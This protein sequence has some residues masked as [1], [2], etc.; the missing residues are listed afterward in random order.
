M[1]TL[2]EIA[3]LVGVSSTTVSRV[4][5]Y[6]P[7]LTMPSTK[8]QAI[9]EAAEAMNYATPRNRGKTME[10]SEATPS[11]RF[12]IVHFLDPSEEIADPFYVGVRLGIENKCRELNIDVTKIFS[13][14]GPPSE[15]LL[16]AASG[17]IVIGKHSSGQIEHLKKEARH[18]VFADFDPGSDEL[19]SVFSDLDVA[20][21]KILKFLKESGYQRI[22]FI[23]TNDI[24]D[25]KAVRYG[26][27]RCA[28]YI[29]WQKKE[30]CY[31]V[32]LV[33]LDDR[34]AGQSHTLDAGY[35]LAREL[36]SKPVRPD[37]IVTANDN[38][39]IGAY[40]AIQELGLAVPDDIGIASYNDI[41]VAQFL[42]PP[43]TTLRIH[44]EYIGEVAVDL[45]LERLSGR[46]HG[47]Q[48]RIATELVVRKST[49]ECGSRQ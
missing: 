2:K 1:V 28:A 43:L 5:N 25:G 37:A 39:A 6:D 10:E 11:K 35:R 21:T 45:L 40:R 22:G 7:T 8:R 44:N 3:K 49:K 15:A 48:V 47:R 12:V 27:I 4:L 23:G 19:D 17:V 24:I 29:N 38:M 30:G 20:T 26:E 16:N 34:A 9:I 13:P 46:E 14:E 36:L 18:L 41:P 32:D 31:D 33:A 42:A